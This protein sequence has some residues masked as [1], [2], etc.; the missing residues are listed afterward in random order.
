MGAT[1]LPKVRI[2]EFIEEDPEFIRLIYQYLAWAA[3]WLLVGSSAGLLASVKM[4]PPTYLH[5][6]GNEILISG[7]DFWSVSW[8]S[9]GRLRMVHTNTVF[10]G[11]TT[12][13]MVA[14]ALYVVPRTSRARLY[15]FPLARVALWLTNFVVAAGLVSL[16]AGINNGTQE[17]RE[18]YWPLAIP[19]ATAVLL[20]LFNLY[21]T[22][23]R[24]NVEEIYISNWYV[25]SSFFWV[26][27]LYTVGYLPWWQ[28]RLGQAIIQGYYMHNGVGM[29]FTPFVVGLM[30]YMLPKF[31]NRPIYSYSLG[32]LAFWTQL[33]FYT[34]IGTHHYVF[35]PIPWWLQTTAIVFSIG[36][37]VPVWAGTGNFLL[38]CKGKWDTIR[39]SYSIPFIVAGVIFYGLA[40]TQGSLEA[41][42]TAN[43]YWHFTNFTVG[44]SHFAMYGF[45][46]FLIWGGVYGLLP[47]LTH[48]EPNILLVGVHFW[49]ALIGLMIYGFSL[50]IGGTE[51]GIAWVQKKPFID[52]V[53][54]QAPY[55]TAR[56]FGGTLMVLSHFIFAY[57]LWLM[58][59]PEAGAA[60]A[61]R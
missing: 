44:H 45:V 55:W 40:S 8:L 38:T 41:L 2:Q 59:R 6:F 23:A 15:S 37:M 39:R 11:W 5:L 21:R 24:R 10:W 60:G 50:S 36:M 46:A 22:V 17:Y 51:Q 54:A 13:A 42:R 61:A 33:V 47:R 34:L 4:L 53:V 30:Y 1:F 32:V 3:F 26:A 14:L 7:P 52:S 49:F 43:L 27:T 58:R 57:N 16:L 25:V 28:H 56:S 20:N 12:L 48:R 31:L 35:S 9:F 29:W 18:Y 19:F